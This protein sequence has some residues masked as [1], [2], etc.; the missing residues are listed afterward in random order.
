VTVTAPARTERPRRLHAA[1]RAAVAL[2]A[3]VTVL[4]VGLAGLFASPASAR[5]LT[6]PETR[7]AA[8]GLATGQI[9][10]A[11]QPILAGQRRARAP[12]YDRTAVGSCVAAETEGGVS[13]AA[14]DGA[15][16][17]PASVVRMVSGDESQADL[18]DELK[19]RTFETGQE[20]ALV[21]LSSGDQAIVSG[22][23]TGIQGMDIDELVA[24]THPYQLPATGPS[25]A[26]YGALN[27]LGQPSSILLEHG[28][29]ITFGVNDAQYLKL[30]GAP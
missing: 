1:F 17:G 11:H 20:H 19:A 23:E 22:G 27:Q 2:M 5:T 7:V 29:E 4:V 12:S 9:V 21:T 26:D 25:D 13:V 14:G 24:H 30:F 16:S 8:F 6:R 10:G 15:S 28:Q 18:F 3:V